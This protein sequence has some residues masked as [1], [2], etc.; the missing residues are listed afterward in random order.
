MKRSAIVLSMALAAPFATL[1]PASA[2]DGPS[3]VQKKQIRLDC[4]SDYLK[5]CS[6]I[7][8]GGLDAL[9]CL[10]THLASLSSTCQNDVNGIEVD[11]KDPSS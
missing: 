8:P 9:N 4:K 5:Y 10:Q 3:D 7:S 6:D 2:Q 1:A 11:L